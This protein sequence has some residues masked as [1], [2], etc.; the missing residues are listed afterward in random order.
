[1][2]G[3]DHH[4]T[5]FS[6]GSVYCCGQMLA[7]IEQSR[8]RIAD[9]CRKY[10]VKRLEL[11]GSAAS[12]DF[13]PAASDIDFFYEF[14][15]ADMIDLADRFFGLKED[16]EQLLMARVDLVSAL[17]VTNPYFLQVANRHR[18]TLYAA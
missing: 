8:S 13:D 6:T 12:G 10:R 5:Y 18:Q 9:L 15:N 11:F 3:G 7:L 4:K 17:D 2:N 14:D 16:L 1:M